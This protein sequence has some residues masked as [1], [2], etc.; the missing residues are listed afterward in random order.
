[1][2]YK[3]AASAKRKQELLDV[4]QG[5]EIKRGKP[6][7]QGKTT[8]SKVKEEN[9]ELLMDNFLG[10]S[11][12]ICKKNVDED[13]KGEQFAV[14]CHYTKHYIQ[15]DPGVL[16][17]MVGWSNKEERGKVFRCPYQSCNPRAMDME[18]LNLHL[19]TSHQHLK[20]LLETDARPE[21]EK[22]RSLFFP[23]IVVS[24]GILNSVTLKMEPGLELEEDSEEVDDPI[25]SPSPYR[26]VTPT[27]SYKMPGPRPRSMTPA[28]RPQL[29]P[30]PIPV[31]S[32]L[33]D[34][35]VFKSFVSQPAPCLLCTDKLGA[36][37]RLGENN[38]ELTEHYKLCLYNQGVLQ[39]LVEAGEEN[40]TEEGD[41]L[42]GYGKRFLYKCMVTDCDKAKRTAKSVSYREHA[43]HCYQSH[44]VMK[45][46]LEAARD[47]ATDMSV[48]EK[49]EVII[50]AVVKDKGPMGPLP[51]ARV[52]EIHTCLLCNGL[53]KDRTKE[54]K[55]G[56]LLKL[57]ICVTRNH[58]A[59]CLYEQDEGREFFEK[60]YPVPS[61]MK[62][63]PDLKFYCPE[64]ACKNDKRFK[65]GMN[66]K[67]FAIH[68]AL[69]H[70]DLDRYIESQGREDLKLMIPKLVCHKDTQ[71]CFV[72]DH[73]R[74]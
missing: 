29:Q 47:M 34:N 17:S 44:G 13:K 48:R 20:D 49:F 32:P 28:I 14:K 27:P 67:Q 46:A 35:G 33:Q 25:P 69:Y 16:L 6:G 36:K 70:G 54:N 31:S 1:M 38:C 42:D 53:T 18:E 12:V 37:L 3:S 57:N 64:D 19:S 55:E 51:L 50:G 40:K 58:Y 23:G 61:D 11:C 39:T 22:V 59:N 62:E 41:I 8:E 4:L 74:Q 10:H 71:R 45:L 73:Y 52:E 26:T 72:T 24:E 43:F 56:K 15:D 5:G 30:R 60:T 2:P 68:S 7:A 9:L 66:H 21:M 65:V 63:R